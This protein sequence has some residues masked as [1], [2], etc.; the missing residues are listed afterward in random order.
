MAVEGFTGSLAESRVRL[1]TV[2]LTLRMAMLESYL[3]QYAV[4]GLVFAVGIYCGLRIGV[5]SLRNP[6]G[7]R[8]L[9]L[10][11]LGLLVFAVLQGVLAW[12]GK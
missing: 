1:H 9:V 8:R 5:F 4:G 2:T 6:E 12:F 7:R 11:A 10:M 3:Y